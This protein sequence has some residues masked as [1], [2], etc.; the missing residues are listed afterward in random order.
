MLLMATDQIRDP[1]MGFILMK[2][3]DPALPRRLACA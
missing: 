2:T 3:D 1:L